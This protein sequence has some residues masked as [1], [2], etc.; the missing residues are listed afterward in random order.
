METTTSPKS[1][2]LGQWLLERPFATPDGHWDILWFLRP[3]GQIHPDRNVN[4][5]LHRRRPRSFQLYKSD[6][7]GKNCSDSAAR[8]EGRLPA[9]FNACLRG[10]HHPEPVA[11][12][13][14]LQYLSGDTEHM[15]TQYSSSTKSSYI[16]KIGLLKMDFF[17]P[18]KTSPSSSTL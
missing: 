7:A 16:E 6:P 3:D 1:S 5:R 14:P 9:C 2:L 11:N 18:Q 8:L 10:R 13:S 15:V 17:G 4:P 12:Y